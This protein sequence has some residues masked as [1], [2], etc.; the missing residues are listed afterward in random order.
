[1]SSAGSG[2]MLIEPTTPG[3]NRS[4]PNT[5]AFTSEVGGLNVACGVLHAIEEYATTFHW[6]PKPKLIQLAGRKPTAPSSVKNDVLR[7][8]RKKR[9]GLGRLPLGVS[10]V[11]SRLPH[12]LSE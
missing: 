6:K 5:S 4:R 8:E 11:P 3:M 9:S 1:M 7:C 2:L 12:W 10:I